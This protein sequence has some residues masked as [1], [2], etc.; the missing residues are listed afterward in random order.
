MNA[1]VP[2][3]PPEPI[4]PAVSV[5]RVVQIS[6]HP[7]A[8]HAPDPIASDEPPP[9]GLDELG[10]LDAP[11]DVEPKH[12]A[13]LPNLADEAFAAMTDTG[14]PDQET[15]APREV[16]APHVATPLPAPSPLPRVATPMPAP[17][18][19]PLPPI[20]NTPVPRSPTNDHPPV[21]PPQPES[22]GWWL[23]ALVLILFAGA[24]FAAFH[25]GYLP[26]KH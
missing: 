3:S 5:Q 24:L 22:R 14:A 13:P 15:P 23:A 18:P 1:I 21:P 20:P 7:A 4:V 17:A 16:A 6:E 19:T 10:G 9:L 2:S 11:S 12:E 26:L 8:L 25:F